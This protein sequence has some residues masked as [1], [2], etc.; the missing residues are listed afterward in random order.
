MSLK[1]GGLTLG[2]VALCL[3]TTVAGQQA[4][5]NIPVLPVVAPADPSDPASLLDAALK[6]DLHLQR[7]LE[8]TIAVSTRNP[9]TILT[10]FNDYRAVDIQNDPGLGE[11]RDSIAQTAW[12]FIKRVFGLFAG[13]K[14]KPNGP[15]IPAAA[16]AAEAWIGGSRSY[17]GGITWSG[18]FVPGAP[19]DNSQASLAAPIRGLQAATD[20]VLAAGPCGRFYLAFLAFTRNGASS[21][22]VARYVD[23]NNES[24]GDTIVYE[25]MTVVESANNASWGYFLDKPSIAVDPLRTA[26]AGCGHNVY[27][28]YT[29]FNGLEKDGKF[30]SKITFAKSSDSGATFATQKL[31]MP[32]GQNQNTV[33]AVDPR[34]GTPSTTG[35][36]TVYVGWR[37]FFAPDTILLH[38]S[39]NFGQTFSGQPVDLLA[40]STVPLLQTF[41]QP[42]A[43]TQNTLNPSSDV[44]FRT[45]SVPTLAVAGDGTVFAAW[46]ER[47]D[48]IPGS[49]TFGQPSPQAA[50]TSPRIVLTRSTDRGSSWSARRAADM[51]DRDTVGAPPPGFGALP[52][53]R[54]SGPQVM[55][56]L[57]FG[58]GRLLLIYYESRGFM[59][60]DQIVPA[61]VT[62]PAPGF[63][64][65]IDRIMD[66]RAAVLNPAT[67]GLL[68]SS[69][70]SR[71]PVRSDADLTNGET[72]ADVAASNG[73]CAP[74]DPAATVPCVRRVHHSNDPHSAA[75]TAPFIG[76]YVEAVPVVQLVPKADQSGWR[77]ATEPSDV[78]YGGFHTVWADNRNL[79][80]PTA[81][82]E[83]PLVQRYPFYSPPVGG[84]VCTNGGSRNTDVLT[85]NVNAALA[86]S[87]PITFK[88][89][90]NVLRAFPVFAHN[91]T[92]QT[93]F[94]R[95][96]FGTQA[97]ADY[98]SFDQ[99]DAAVD[100]L[101]VQLFA[102]SGATR[103]V[104]LP[105]GGV[106]VP[107]T[108]LVQETLTLGGAVA[109]GGLTGTVAINVDGSNPPLV[110]AN[111]ATTEVY[112]PGIRTPGIRT[113]GIR[114]PGIRTPGIRTP[115]IRT[116]A[117]SETAPQGT[118]YAITDVTWTVSNEGNTT[119]A[120][121]SLVNIDNPEQY[122]GS[123]EFQLIVSKGAF[124][125]ALDGC[126]STGLGQD[127]VLAV[128]PNPS[129]RTPSIRTPGIRTPGI[130]TATFF[131]PPSESGTSAASAQMVS[132]SALTAPSDGT[133]KAAAS[134]N[135][136]EVTL[137]A[138]QMV[139]NPPVLFEPQF[140]PPSVA[141][142]AQSCNTNGI[143]PDAFASP[144]LA[145]SVEPT[146]SATAVR[147]GGSFTVSSGVIVNGGEGPALAEDSQFRDGAYL[148]S[149]PGPDG[150]FG[151]SDDLTAADTVFLGSVG[152]TSGQLDEGQTGQ[153]AGGTLTVPGGTASG[154]YTLLLMI[155]DGR[156]VSE[157]DEL[158]NVIAMPFTVL[159]PNTAPAAADQA[160]TTA[161]DT[162]A[163]VTLSATDAE[164]NT[165]TFAVVS[166]PSHG[167]LGGSAPNLTYM[168]QANYFG[169]DSFT[170]RANDGR[171][172]SNVATVSIEVTPVNDAPVAAGQSVTTTEDVSIAIALSASDV[173]ADSLSFAVVAG[174]SH[175]SL[176]GI[177]PNLTYTPAPNYFGSDSFTFRAT[178]GSLPS[179]VAI[180]S[181]AVGGVNDAPVANADAVTIAENSGTVLIDVLS[182]DS[183][184]EGSA[185]SLVAV[186]PPTSGTAAISAG[187]I[188]YTPATN[189]AGLVTLTYVVSDGLAS[190]TGAV[191]VN[192]D[193]GLPDY[194]FIG[195]QSP[196]VPGASVKIGS[197]FPL[198]WQYTVGGLVVD[199]SAALPEIRIRGPYNCSQSESATTV[200][201]VADP[202]SSGF[203]YFARTNTWQFNWQTADLGVG[204]YAVR[205]FSRQTRQ[206]NGPFVIRL[207]R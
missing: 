64:S 203:Q 117:I 77:W 159:E 96:S 105:P 186:S 151:T 25:G 103:V 98:A 166:A 178:D 49:A 107:V 120:Y 153:I 35:G 10:F 5:Q 78:P 47:V 79:V 39:T 22:V 202:G 36:G 195:L 148:V 158:N 130:R 109:P 99:F 70:I 38:T 175:G 7:Q 3:H 63:I 146:V 81:P 31:N 136:V 140:D 147:A 165:L 14:A 164:G 154:T 177:A 75:G 55:P 53:P 83:L 152:T 18:L 128:I 66:L 73:P 182:N 29:T 72:L 150:L 59:Q 56:K 192:V 41:D 54:A 149:G 139:P 2:I 135:V 89:L 174:P 169:A 156:E 93:R 204:C 123:Y 207:R 193:G 84:V 11:S 76:D 24:G 34:E 196:W 106:N 170:F 160:I 183:D 8:P 201:F 157:I 187:R 104:Y 26:S 114:T 6:G 15:G 167:T 200:E 176:T 50:D 161:E 52:Q 118:V 61:D 62:P 111:I 113:P 190:A 116:T 33:I 40:G 199:S 82:A 1:R 69:Q 155:D 28:A 80:R 91:A 67:G 133:T 88:Q 198:V 191:T 16:A 194:G 90:E 51:G 92:P 144:D 42:T 102:F 206:L 145:Y 137:R 94:F 46:Q 37:H 68:G 12:S 27:L 48:R 126:S 32:Y 60:S 122:E 143:C 110:N 141:V 112:S 138:Y 58:G 131:I 197:A 19:F 189:F 30:K 86:V 171:L 185:L 87:A 134:P 125:G 127:Q 23:L 129:I 119:A 172:D 184:Q 9:N 13:R 101:D 121:S 179:N 71:Y 45:N 115:G 20:P 65:G 168:P 188:A 74:D 97:M 17:D 100:S 95:F 205:I 44:S 180:V 173:E 43:T 181:I 132:A 85:S 21:M 162:A 163:P 108:V 57:A 4:G 124:G 142:L